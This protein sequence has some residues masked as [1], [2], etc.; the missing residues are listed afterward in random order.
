MHEA[1][2]VAATPTVYL[3]IGLPKTGTT[4]LQHALW[5]SRDRLREDGVLVPGAARMD[6]SFAVWDLLGRRPRDGEQPGVAG[7]WTALVDTVRGWSGAGVVISEELLAAATAR[8]ATRAVRALEPA[9]VEVVVTVRDLERVVVGAWQQ[10]LV[11]GRTWSLRNYLASVRD[12]GEGEG[13][14][15]VAFWLRQDVVR[16]LDTWERAV[17]RGQVHLVTVPPP[18][19]PR[20]LLL[21]RF[22]AVVGAPREALRVEQE[23]ANTTVGTAEAEVLRRLNQRLDGTLNERQYVRVVKRGVHPVLQERNSPPPPFPAEHHDWAV[24]TT[25]ATVRTLEERGYAV[26]GDLTDLLPREPEP[27]PDGEPGVPGEGAVAEAALDALA[28]VSSQLG[29]SWW[30]NRR[31]ERADAATG[32]GQLASNRRASVY[33]ARLAVLRLGERSRLVRRLMARR[34]RAGQSHGTG[35]P[36][37]RT[38]PST[39]TNSQE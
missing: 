23:V 28:A 38:S 8:Q 19:A 36:R 32:L 12:P 2:P 24:E 5:D 14:A 1:S 22:A 35:P 11:K 16:V 6:Q 31:K 21:D 18:G 26:A 20:G 37:S 25:R 13:T 30:R 4:Y 39:P 15:G 34:V 3:H 27:V 33:R 29:D 9:R 7:S 17:P 10:E